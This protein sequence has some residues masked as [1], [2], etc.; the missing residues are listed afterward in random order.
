MKLTDIYSKIIS[1]EPY[2]DMDVFFENYE[3]FEEIPH[4]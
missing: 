3:S 2:N 1:E 4:T